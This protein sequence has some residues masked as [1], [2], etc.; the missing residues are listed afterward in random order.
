MV[1]T[2]YGPG[3]CTFASPLYQIHCFS[4]LL[5][6]DRLNS[7]PF[8]S[9]LQYRYKVQEVD[10]IFYKPESVNKNICYTILF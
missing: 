7:W 9:F 10:Q 2:I 5:D 8:L 3:G 4:L 1:S 6:Q